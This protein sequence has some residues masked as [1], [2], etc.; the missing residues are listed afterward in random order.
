MS[1]IFKQQYTALDAKGG[2]VKKKSAHWYI[3]YK[4]ADGV[5]KRVRGFKDK[6]ATAQLAAKLEKE[7]ELAEVGI[8]DRHKEH[9]NRPLRGH[10]D[11]F[12]A[13]LLA[14]GNTKKHAGVVFTRAK[15]VTDGCGFTLIGD[16]SASKVHQY[17]AD[18]R[19]SGA[20][21]R[22]SNGYLQ[23]SKQFF[24]VACC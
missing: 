19:G 17:L 13:S 18:L 10:L 14:K 16:V 21:I 6:T 20:S 4:G 8:V 23:A 1:S 7:A 9:R 11:D 3:D 15:A 24:S 2:R 22:T 12:T 5:R